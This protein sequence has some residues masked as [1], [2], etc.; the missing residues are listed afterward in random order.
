MTQQVPGAPTIV[1]LHD[2]TIAMFRLTDQW[3]FRENV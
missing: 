1:N 3:D 2:T